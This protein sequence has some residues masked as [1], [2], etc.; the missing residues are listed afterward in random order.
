[1]VHRGAGLMLERDASPEAIAAAVRTLLEDPA[2]RQ[3]ART[4]G[5]AIAAD[6]TGRRAEDL[7]EALL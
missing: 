6:L 4:L 5:D 2:Y 7:L 1:V 3:A